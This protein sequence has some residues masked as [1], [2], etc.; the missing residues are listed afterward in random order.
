[1]TP[2]DVGGMKCRG[3]IHDAHLRC[4]R[5]DIVTGLRQAAPDTPATTAGNA[6]DESEASPATFPVNTAG[7][8]RRQ[9]MGGVIIGKSTRAHRRSP[10][11]SR[12]HSLTPLAFPL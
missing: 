6:G 2:D 5:P 7:P 10:G 11:H 9:E 3:D 12:Y 1:M 8:S 4:A